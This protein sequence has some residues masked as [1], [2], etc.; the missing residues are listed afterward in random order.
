LDGSRF[1]GEKDNAFG[2]TDALD[3]KCLTPSDI[4]ADARGTAPHF[5]PK[6]RRRGGLDAEGYDTTGATG[7]G[8]TGPEDRRRP[9]IECYLD[10]EAGDR[11]D[12]APLPEESQPWEQNEPP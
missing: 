5:G 9:P 1:E 10:E 3:L 6:R 11:G 7:P 12:D 8:Q 2:A 4:P